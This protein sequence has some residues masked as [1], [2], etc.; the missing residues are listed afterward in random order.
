MTI[1]QL[2]S[3]LAKE[4]QDGI[5]SRFPCR[6][7]MV[8]NVQQYSELLSKLNK[9][10]DIA[11]VPSGDLFSSADVMP[12]YENLKDAKYWDRW[13]VLPGVSEYLR[14]FSKS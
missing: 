8:K 4:K 14:L 13:L 7:V 6:V 2:V 12:R 11:T 5:T 10:P 1:D 3:E 9:I